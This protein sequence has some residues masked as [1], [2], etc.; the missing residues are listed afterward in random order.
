MGVP[1]R[2]P[3]TRFAS[4]AAFKLQ[5]LTKTYI[6]TIRD[7]LQ[8]LIPMPFTMH[9]AASHAQI[10]YF[11]PRTRLWGSSD[12][13]CLLELGPVSSHFINASQ[14]ICY[15]RSPGNEKSSK[16]NRFNYTRVPPR[17]QITDFNY[18]RE[19]SYKLMLIFND[20]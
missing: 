19:A 8:I 3:V 7:E 16:N 20:S 17:C 1:V 15:F 14:L 5:N 12:G 9:G 10:C 11:V 4:A 2:A 13:A 18:T 6:L